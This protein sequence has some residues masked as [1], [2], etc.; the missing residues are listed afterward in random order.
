MIAI[1]TE[2]QILAYMAGRR[3]VTTTEL[4]KNTQKSNRTIGVRLNHLIELDIIKRNGT[5]NDPK[6]TYEKMKVNTKYV[7]ALYLL[8]MNRKDKIEKKCLFCDEIFNDREL[9]DKHSCNSAS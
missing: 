6:Q 5:R 2:K 9:F 7:K 1:D 4:A 3:H 8:E